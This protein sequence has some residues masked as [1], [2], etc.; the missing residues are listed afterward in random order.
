MLRSRRLGAD[1]KAKFLLCGLVV[2]VDHGRYNST[3]V[4]SGMIRCFYEV[5]F[6]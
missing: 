5:A 2:V 4:L 1:T 6:C 3:Y